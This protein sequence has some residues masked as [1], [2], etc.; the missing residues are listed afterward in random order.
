VKILS[1]NFAVLENDSHVSR[2][3]EETGRLD[4]DQYSLSY[5]LKYIKE[6]DCVVDAG[7]FIGDHTLAYLKAV[8]PRGK[9]IAFEP[10]PEAYQ[11]L[12][13]N[14]PEAECVLA[15]LGDKEQ[16]LYFA[17]DQN[18]AASHISCLGDREVNIVTLD[19]YKLNRLDF[20][21]LDVEG[22]EISALRGAK[23]TIDRFRP[24]MWI[25]VNEGALNRNHETATSLL[26][27]I[28]SDLCY[29]STP[30]P[31]VNPY[32]YDILCRPR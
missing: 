20:L 11:C 28:Q 22:F 30:F 2:W 7:A 13:H 5:I 4:H 14:C 8:G 31:E 17:V 18:V 10:N 16:K 19:S 15:G 26:N 1:N 23:K 29:E 32:Q 21:K 6:G 9:V 12:L 27:F 25:E 24:T 3:V